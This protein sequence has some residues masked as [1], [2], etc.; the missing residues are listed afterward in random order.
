MAAFLQSGR[1]FRKAATVRSQSPGGHDPHIYVE[2]GLPTMYL[3]VPP[4]PAPD[5]MLPFILSLREAL[6]EAYALQI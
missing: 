3:W 4:R 5:V 6:R 1:V 2:P